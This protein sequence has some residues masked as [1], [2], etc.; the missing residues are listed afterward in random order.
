MDTRHFIGTTP[1]HRRRFYWAIW[2][3]L[4]VWLSAFLFLFCCCG[5]VDVASIE[6]E[7][8]H[9]P[10]DLIYMVFILIQKLIRWKVNRDI[11][12]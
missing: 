12:V 2:S 3:I 6:G 7:N 1:Q 11:H 4:N 8:L 5:K 9:L 10:F